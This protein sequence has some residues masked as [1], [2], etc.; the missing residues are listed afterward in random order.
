MTPSNLRITSFGAAAFVTFRNWR[1]LCPKHWTMVIEMSGKFQASDHLP[2]ECRPEAAWNR[3]DRRC[4]QRASAFRSQGCQRTQIVWRAF[5]LVYGPGWRD[6]SALLKR[7]NASVLPPNLIVNICISLIMR[8]DSYWRRLNG[9]V[10]SF[11]IS[12]LMQ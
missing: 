6:Q 4:C 11:S 2:P 1:M 8:F 10:S 5:D 12:S 9:G 3:N 7:Y